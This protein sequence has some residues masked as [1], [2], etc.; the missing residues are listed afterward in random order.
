MEV[1][2]TSITGITWDSILYKGTAA[3]MISYPEKKGNTGLYIM[4]EFKNYLNSQI[5]NQ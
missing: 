5:R 3:V 4:S 1:T 2:T